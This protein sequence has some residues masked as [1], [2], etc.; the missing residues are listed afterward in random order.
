MLPRAVM[1]R[2]TSSI[3]QAAILELLER[4]SH[5]C[6]KKLPISLELYIVHLRVDTS[7]GL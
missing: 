3:E 4:R 6:P 1:L 7:E 5:D 2:G